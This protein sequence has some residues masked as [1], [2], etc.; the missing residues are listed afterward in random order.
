MLSNL[1]ELAQC[2]LTGDSW[3]FLPLPVRGLVVIVMSVHAGPRFTLVLHPPWRQ[4]WDFNRS[5]EMRDTEG[6]VSKRSVL[7][8]VDKMKRYLKEEQH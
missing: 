8:Q 2:S 4:V 1:L 3:P 6:G 5:A 7:E